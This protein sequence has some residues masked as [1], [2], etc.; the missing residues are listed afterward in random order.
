MTPQTSIV[1]IFLSGRALPEQWFA[2][3]IL[4]GIGL[5]GFVRLVRIHVRD[6]R[7]EGRA[8]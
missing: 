7:D 8:K 1:E 4:A 6:T 5:Y 3:F 2:L